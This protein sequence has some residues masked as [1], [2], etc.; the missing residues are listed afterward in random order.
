MSADR[1]MDRRAVGARLKELRRRAGGATQFDTAFG[2]DVKPRTFQS[3]ENGAVLTTRENYERVADY[4][5]R[6]LADDVTADWIMYGNEG[7]GSLETFVPLADVKTPDRLE[8]IEDDLARLETKL[9]RLLEFH[10]DLAADQAI[11]AVE[12]ATGSGGPTA[13]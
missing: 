10:A 11:S 7:P 3:W 4:Y 2:L 5:D 6:K 9:D 12:R 8:R 1:G 13:P